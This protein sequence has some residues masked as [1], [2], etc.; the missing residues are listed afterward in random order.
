MV[1]V[2]RVLCSLWS[3]RCIFISVLDAKASEVQAALSLRA[4]LLSVR[5]TAR[6][7]GALRG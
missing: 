3:T 4:E 7:P 1:C 5:D 6:E 2:Y